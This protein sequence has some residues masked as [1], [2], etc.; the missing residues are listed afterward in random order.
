MIA[1]F[2]IAPIVL[3]LAWMFAEFRGGK[4]TRVVLGIA[5]IA[6]VAVMAFCWGT[7]L[8]EFK[9]AE[10]PVP[11]DSPIDTA[12]MNGTNEVATNSA[13]KEARHAQEKE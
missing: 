5:A 9:H 2:S 12:I 1:I 11:H 4:S 8:G 7:F 13:A 3:V 10:F 6:G